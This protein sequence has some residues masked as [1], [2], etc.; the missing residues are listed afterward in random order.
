MLVGVN[1]AHDAIHGA[2]F[3][4]KWK[5]TLAGFS[6]DL[7]GISSYS[8]RLKHNV[9]HHRYPNVTG[10][11]FDIEAGP[12]LRLSPAEKRRWFHRFQHIYAPLVYCLF[13]LHMLLVTDLVLWRQK[14]EELD[15]KKH[16]WF[17]G[18]ILLLQ[19]SFYILMMV[20]LP[21]YILPFSIWQVLGGFLLMHFSLSLLLALILLPSHLFEHTSF[22]SRNAAGEIQKDW[23]RHQIDTTLDFAARN[24]LVHF[25]FGGFNTNVV[26]HLFPQVCHCH[27]RQLSKII[28]ERSRELR[29][30]YHQTTL[31]SAI[32]SHFRAL[33]KLGKGNINEVTWLS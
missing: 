23:A 4:K 15:G 19:K 31:E 2:L 33:K 26:H 25:L 27:Y 20:V 14:R 24:R 18:L 6:F 3:R 12:F 32:A 16:P 21:A 22:D 7:I 29:I 9:I 5:N 11:D 28:D 10:V 8:W 1:I 30:A 13:S 17:L